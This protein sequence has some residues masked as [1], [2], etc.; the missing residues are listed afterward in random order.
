MSLLRST[1]AIVF[2]APLLAACAGMPENGQQADT[3]KGTVVVGSRIPTKIQPADVST[4]S[5][6]AVDQ[7]RK[8]SQLEPK[9][10]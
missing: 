5:G 7:A 4:A 10:R 3:D 2:I 1:V 8:N 6:N 9:S